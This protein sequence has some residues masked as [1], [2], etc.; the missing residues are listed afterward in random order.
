MVGSDG[1]ILKGIEI[2]SETYRGAISKQPPLPHGILSR[3]IDEITNC[4]YVR[5]HF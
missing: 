5:V 4:S 2:N 1:L 3:I